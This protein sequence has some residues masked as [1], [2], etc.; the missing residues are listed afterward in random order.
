M[1]RSNATSIVHD[2]HDQVS[3]IMEGVAWQGS[4]RRRHERRKPLRH[5][6]SYF[7]NCSTVLVPKTS[8]SHGRCPWSRLQWRC[9]WDAHGAVCAVRFR[10]RVPFLTLPYPTL[11]YPLLS[12]S[13]PS[14]FFQ[15]PP[16]PSNS[17]LTPPPAG[18]NLFL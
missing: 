4:G 11:P 18:H 6:L 7:D 5:G 17:K 15:S 16:I 8:E 2:Q 12:P 14:Y 10:F 1:T 13:I 9:L 3:L